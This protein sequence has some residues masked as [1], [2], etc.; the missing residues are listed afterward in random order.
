M[1]LATVIPGPN[2]PFLTELNH[3]IRPVVDQ[4]LVSWEQ[5]TLWVLNE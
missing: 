1:F 4:F 5:Q 3:Y 2:E